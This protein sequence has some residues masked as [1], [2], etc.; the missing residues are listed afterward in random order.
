MLVHPDHLRSDGYNTAPSNSSATPSTKKK[1][2]FI[3]AAFYI[4]LTTS[5]TNFQ[6]RVCTKVI[7]LLCIGSFSSSNKPKGILDQ[8]RS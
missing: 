8:F 1:V 6:A 2:Y 7:R 4:D 3:T 5:S